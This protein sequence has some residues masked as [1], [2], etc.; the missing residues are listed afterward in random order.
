VSVVYASS[1]V[2]HGV[3]LLGVT[4]VLAT[5]DALCRVKRHY[6]R[7]EFVLAS[8]GSSTIPDET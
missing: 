4:V 8:H 5:D 1:T 3:S 6:G 7:V 2:A